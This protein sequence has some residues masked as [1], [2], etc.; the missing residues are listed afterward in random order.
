MLT[1]PDLNSL[2]LS[3]VHQ[4]YDG[5]FLPYQEQWLNLGPINQGKASGRSSSFSF[6]FFIVVVVFFFFFFFLLL[7]IVGLQQYNVTFKMINDHYTELQALGFHSL[8]Y[9][10][11][12]PLGKRK[13]ERKKEKRKRRRQKE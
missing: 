1:G 5:L 4:P 8:S 10:D 6:F 13:K 12:G 11:I 9:Y 2:L 3:V 7:S